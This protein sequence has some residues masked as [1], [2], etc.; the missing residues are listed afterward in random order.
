MA[1][2]LLT[3][4]DVTALCQVSPKT[5]MRAI[6]AGDLRAA[7]LG[8]RGALRISPEDVDAW[9]DRNTVMPSDVPDPRIVRK[10]GGRVL[11]R[12][13]LLVPQQTIKR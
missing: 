6:K 4:S 13:R 11:E 8:K 9:L 10:L 12:G 2:P 5:V 7:R 3:A 1:D